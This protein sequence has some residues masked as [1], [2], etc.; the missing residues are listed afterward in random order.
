ML[1]ESVS[2]GKVGTSAIFHYLTQK[3]KMLAAATI[4]VVI[5]GERVEGSELNPASTEE[6]GGVLVVTANIGA[7]HGKTEESHRE[8]EGEGGGEGVK[9][10]CIVAGPMLRYRSHSKN[11]PST[12][13]E[14]KR[15]LE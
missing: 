9:A 6:R 11:V 1:K 7:S 14:R 8:E 13:N 15:C 2:E 5:S 10:C 4:I 3:C 12:Q